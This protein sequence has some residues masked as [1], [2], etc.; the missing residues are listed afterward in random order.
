M[1]YI[2]IEK[3]IWSARYEICRNA[4]SYGFQLK[5]IYV[6]GSVFDPWKLMLSPFLKQ[7]TDN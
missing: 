1:S 2:D 6:R 7:L 5:K 3:K 4:N